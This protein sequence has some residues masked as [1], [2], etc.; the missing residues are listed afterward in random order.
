MTLTVV[1]CADPLN[2]RRVEPHFAREAAAVRDHYGNVVLIEHDAL[3]QGDVLTAIRRVPRHLGPAW[4]RGWMLTGAEYTALA[5]ALKERG[6]PL[7][8]HPEDYLRAHEL[9]GWHDT[10]AGLTPMS[11]WRPLP[12]RTV[13]DDLAELVRPL[14]PGPAV[15][16]DYVK[17]RKHEWE[18]ACY[19]PDVKNVAQLRSIVAKMVA[20]Q[21]DFLAGGLVV[22]EYESYDTGEARVWWVDGEPALIGPHPD[23]PDLYPEP[24]L[25]AVAMAVRAL[26]CRF[27]TTDLAR[28][29]DGRWRVVEV[30]DGQ[31]S[32]LPSTVDPMDLYAHLPIPE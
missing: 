4:Y 30:G 14:P 32:D 20:L 19:V 6:T 10:F 7:L 24:E 16:K 28:R 8:T 3:R 18:E 17:S 9:P 31:V 27:I 15:V 11:V 12:P 25:D 13:P 2:P 5:S 29:T 26:G 1:F 22:R 21:E 23:E